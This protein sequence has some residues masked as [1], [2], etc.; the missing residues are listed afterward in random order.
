MI[1]IVLIL[2]IVTGDVPV[3]CVFE[4]L[5]GDW[6]VWMDLDTFR[7]ELDDKRTFCDRSLPGKVIN[8]SKN[9][10]FEFSNFSK[11]LIT[12]SLPNKAYSE[13]LGE[14]TW[15]L[16][17]DEGF[18]LSFDEKVF[19]TFFFYYKNGDDY[20]SVCTRTTK[21]WYRG[22]DPKDH[23][24]WGCFYA[25]K[26]LP[27]RVEYS[28]HMNE[29]ESFEGS[30]MSKS[31]LELGMN[32]KHS[33]QIPIQ[34]GIVEPP[35]KKRKLADPSY[36][37]QTDHASL[38]HYWSTPLSQIDGESLPSSWDWSNISSTSFISSSVRQQHSCGSCYAITTCEMLE[39]R[40]KILT[41][42]T[43]T[44]SLSVQYLIS[45][46]FYT[47]GC[48]GGYPTLLHKFIQ[49]FG[50]ISEDCMPYT[51]SESKCSLQTCPKSKIFIKDYYYIGGFYGASNEVNIMKELRARGPVIIDL[52]PGTSFVY[53]KGG[54]LKETS[55]DP[56]GRF[57]GLSLRDKMKDWERVT[58][59]V[60]L[61]GWGEENGEK[62]WKCLNS[63]GNDWGEA[64][65][66]RIRRGTDEDCIE[67]MAEAAVP[68]IVD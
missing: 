61:V 6:Q 30:R 3:H 35:K 53:Y 4:D 16:V 62:Y 18:I 34:A 68:V 51:G 19:N 8:Y 49:E 55:N 26:V 54:I 10:K 43:Y 27:G 28:M 63:W 15:T 7:V 41:N 39:S 46:S 33:V 14:G 64:G 44:D 23:E 11:D 66:F 20:K 37:S 45:C 29:G 17:Y 22:P 50:I 60:L 2:G 59:S 57:E 65:F 5:V 67:S 25:E 42:N 56:T 32:V 13:S 12:F 21:G 31:F 40:L 38:I 52:D 24:N 58:H 1:F 9:Y 47:E 48:S 36:L